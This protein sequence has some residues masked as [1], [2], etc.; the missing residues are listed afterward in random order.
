M[1]DQE[2]RNVKTRL[3][4]YKIRDAYKSYREAERAN[5]DCWRQNKT[6]IPAGIRTKYEEIW[7]SYVIEYKQKTTAEYKKKTNWLYEKWTPTKRKPPDILNGITLKDQELS[8]EFSSDPRIYGNAEI[9]HDEQEVLNLPPEYGLYRKVNVQTMTIETEK[10]MNKLRWKNIIGDNERE[11][12][13]IAN[14]EEDRIKKVTINNLKF[15]ELPFT[16]NVSIPILG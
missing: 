9:D 6:K 16:P 2:K 11:E 8:T 7:K 12:K 15:P 10:A 13:P 5:K 3:M 4:T 1:K 14:N